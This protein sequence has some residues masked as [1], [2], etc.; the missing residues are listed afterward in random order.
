[1]DLDFTGNCNGIRVYYENIHKIQQ[2]CENKKISIISIVGNSGTGKTF[3]LKNMMNH[4]IDAFFNCDSHQYDCG[5]WLSSKPVF[6][7]KSK[8]NE[9]IHVLLM[10]T[11]GF[12]NDSICNN[13]NNFII[14]LTVKVSSIILVNVFA[15]QF[16]CFY[17]KIC[18]KHIVYVLRDSE[19]LC[20]RNNE[21]FYLPYPGLTV[22]K[23]Q[24][25]VN[26]VTDDFQNYVNILFSNLTQSQGIESNFLKWN[27]LKRILSKFSKKDI[28]SIDT[29][30]NSKSLVCNLF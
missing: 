16:D 23:E 2:A 11:P 15:Y 26:N 8:N 30:K 21:F 14:S 4:N 3:L 20:F 17:R 7:F 18:S 9:E 22:C 1:M 13:I 5:I 19:N 28:H 10:D 12:F 6:S 25:D 29:M 24:P 27:K